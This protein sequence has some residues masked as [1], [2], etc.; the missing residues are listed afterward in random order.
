MSKLLSTAVIVTLSLNASGSS[1][2]DVKDYIKKHM[3]K[4]PRVIVESVDIIGKTNLNEPKGWE[5][6]FVNIHAN[7]KKSPTVTDKVN[8]PETIFIK[9]GFAAPSLINMKTGEDFK[10]SMKPDLQSDIYN[11]QH[12]FAGNRNAKHKIVIFSDPH[13]P[14]CQEKV[15][16]IYN[17][18]KANPKIFALYYYHF[19]LL[20]IHP[21]AD[22]ITR[23][24]VVEQKK[25]NFDKVMEIYSLKIDAHESNA[26]K[27]LN[28]I[29]KKFNLKITEQDINV[30]N[31]ADE[32]K[33][34]KE[35]ATKSMVAG[36]PTVYV[37]GKWDKSRNG[38]KDLIPTDKKK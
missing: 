11:D 34:D 14:F 5:V 7:I 24:M 32:I 2:V 35:I 19:P 38:Y 29:N 13:C 22:V 10:I 6:Y 4:S 33:H 20:R 15:P 21:V 31:I 16:E 1:E 36:T 27:I 17:V 23:V 26:T 28:K 3:V 8:V 12:H 30:K 9:D 25:G 18:V 37:D